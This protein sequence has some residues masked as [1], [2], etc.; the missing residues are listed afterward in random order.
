MQ[1]NR[2]EQWLSPFKATVE[3][4]SLCALENRPEIL[5]QLLSYACE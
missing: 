5:P 4:Q 3:G 1:V 2:L